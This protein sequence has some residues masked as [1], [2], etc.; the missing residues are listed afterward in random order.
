MTKLRKGLLIAFEGIDGAG[1]STQAKLLYERLKKAGFKAVF[2]KEP[3]EGEWGQKL[4]KLIEKGRNVTP[5]EELEWFIKDRQQHVE[6]TIIPGLNEKKIIIL[7]RYYFST[8]AYQG[9]LGFDPGEIERKN[10]EFAPQPDLLF[11]IEITPHLGLRRIIEDREKEADHFEKEGYLLQVNKNFNELK[12]PFLHRLPGEEK[13][14]RLSDRT[15]N[16]AA[17]Y[18]KEH[19]LIENRVKSF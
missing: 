7:D 10:L 5:Q 4:K 18:L 16:I 13:I 1:K 3:T 17:R 11:L 2:S 8:I 15:W 12:K 14:Q 19:H 6:K 9:A